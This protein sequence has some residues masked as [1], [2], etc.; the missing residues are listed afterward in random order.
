MRKTNVQL[1]YF[2]ACYS[3]QVYTES[4]IYRMC[5]SKMLNSVS[6]VYADQFA[7]IIHC[8]KTVNAY[9]HNTHTNTLAH[10]LPGMFY[11]GLT[12]SQT[13]SKENL[14]TTQHWR[15][16]L[17]RPNRLGVTQLYIVITVYDDIVPDWVQYADNKL[18]W[19]VKNIGVR[20]GGHGGTSVVI[21]WWYEARWL[22]ALTLVDSWLSDPNP[23]SGCSAGFY[24]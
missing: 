16:Y 1:G 5:L 2:T 4:F 9:K 8:V 21:I 15:E 24:D 3:K 19:W 20:H 11:S 14:W 7:I 13:S 23:S 6:Y 12:W 17:Y 18:S 22:M 10:C